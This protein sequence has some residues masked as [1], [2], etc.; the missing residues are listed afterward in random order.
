MQKVEGV[1]GLDERY[2]GSEYAKGE[3][4]KVRWIRLGRLT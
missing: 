1:E 4:A 3:R 2:L